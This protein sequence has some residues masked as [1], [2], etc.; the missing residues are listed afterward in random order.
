MSVRRILC[1]VGLCVWT[2]GLAECIAPRPPM[3]GSQVD[4]A[5]FGVAFT[6]IGSGLIAASV[7]ETAKK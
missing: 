2:L 4:G 3:S 7:E 5:I 1:F 6:L